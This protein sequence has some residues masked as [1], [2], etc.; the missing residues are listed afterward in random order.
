MCKATAHLAVLRQRRLAAGTALTKYVER[1]CAEAGV[2]GEI[3]LQGVGDRRQRV[4]VELRLFGAAR[5]ALFLL[6]LCVLL[7]LAILLSALLLLLLL[8]FIA[9][10]LLALL[11][12]PSA[13]RASAAAAAAAAP[14]VGIANVRA[15]WRTHPVRRQLAD[16]AQNRHRDRL[17]PGENQSGG[18]GVDG[19]QRE[20]THALRVL[21]L[22]DE[23]GPLLRGDQ[24]LRDALAAENEGGGASV[25]G[26]I[27]A[28]NKAVE[29][30][31]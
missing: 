1:L 27:G 8:L 10:L 9:I 14:L 28:R 30:A 25:S 31:G 23:R 29:G 11:L 16:G 15:A 17:L 7:L 26:G 6:F 5:I 21:R 19:K 18:G 4:A 22:R 2:G 3:A 20:P 12:P 13:A 24:S